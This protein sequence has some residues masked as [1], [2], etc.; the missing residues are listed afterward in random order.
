MGHPAGLVLADVDVRAAE[1]G[2]NAGQYLL[3]HFKGRRQLRVEP[4]GSPF[5]IGCEFDLDEISTAVQ[6]RAHLHERGRVPRR[7]YLGNDG[8]EAVLGA[9]CEPAKVF[10]AVE[11]V[12]L[13]ALG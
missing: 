9:G 8:D 4:H 12:R 2:G 5:V 10:G 13:R 6:L 3:G 1:D 11:G 7:V